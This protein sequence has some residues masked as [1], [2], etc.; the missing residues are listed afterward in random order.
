MTRT[1]WTAALPAVALLAAGCAGPLPAPEPLQTASPA[2]WHSPLPQ[3]TP[4]QNPQLPHQGTQADLAR[5]WQQ[6]DDPLVAE[7]VSAAQAASPTLAAAQSRL[8][9]AQA[10]RTAAGAALLPTLDASASI[11]RGRAEIGGPLAT[12]T[13]AGA[14]AAWE[15]DVFGAGRAGRSA[16]I[17][18]LSGAEAGWHDARVLVAA[19][20]AQSYVALRA[21]EAQWLQTQT[22]A[23][24]RIE[25]ARLT[26][27][28][29][30]AGFQPPANEALA[31]ASAAQARAQLIAQTAQCDLALKSLVALTAIDE[32]T[33]RG[34]LEAGRAKLPAPSQLA[35]S[36]V[37]AE[38]L[39]QRPDVAAAAL[40]VEAAS[41]DVSEAQADR[42]P[43]VSLLGSVTRARIDTAGFS[44]EGNL[45]TLGPLSVSLPIFDAGRRAANVDAARARY[46]EAVANYRG[47]LREAVREVES[48]LVQLA[49]TAARRD[50][51]SL[52]VD[53]FDASFRA[54]E[55]R[56]RG[57]L[58][59]LFELEDARRSAA[60]ARSQLIDLE[61]E[62]VSAWIALYRALG[63]GWKADLAN[64]V[65]TDVAAR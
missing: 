50:D 8:A 10:A 60:L 31:Q 30:K 1:T 35:V 26:T 13:L 24:S 25:T 38:T 34:K 48:A 58:A 37:P 18:R 33:L 21:C 51:A 29:A 2:Q 61:R 11:S 32:S 64:D 6:F 4:G 56:Y 44:T 9:Q 49:S 57:G 47:K 20:A 15:I 3:D 27:L 54:A 46:D 23:S 40:A 28:S 14:Q 5:W 36:A 12:T 53:G 43:R 17:A 39:G 59:S 55:A 7:L 16:A 22:D 42:L 41:A 63:G 19:E 45:W 62:R 52:A 65:R